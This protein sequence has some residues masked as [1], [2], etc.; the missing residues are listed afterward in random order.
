M[1]RQAL[2][3]LRKQAQNLRAWPLLLGKA[4]AWRSESPRQTDTTTTQGAGGG[5]AE[6][7]QQSPAHGLFF[8]AEQLAKG[9]ERVEAE[10]TEPPG[11]L[12]TVSGKSPGG[13][14][15]IARAPQ[16]Q[17][18]GL[19]PPRSRP[20]PFAAA[21]AAALSPQLT[22]L[23]AEEASGSSPAA[24][25]ARSQPQQP[26]RSALAAA[27]RTEPAV[28]LAPQRSLPTASPTTAA[29]AG[30]SGE[31]AIL[32]RLRATPTPRLSPARPPNGARRSRAGLAPPTDRPADRPPGS[33]SSW[34]ALPRS[35]GSLTPCPAEP[36]GKRAPPRQERKNQK[37]SR[38][39]SGFL[40]MDS[41][42]SQGV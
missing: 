39:E 10:Q 5:Q 15:G 20:P 33:P 37:G 41:F 14:Q 38:T 2:M 42:R 29:S 8:A 16:R 26:T 28:W 19:L 22:S 12:P 23:L 34:L 17:T 18:T 13:R 24:W 27:R 11:Q 21:A 6:T 31:A 30:R 35:H 4:P 1:S 36:P 32:R 40:L 7:S 3:P 25:W 9:P